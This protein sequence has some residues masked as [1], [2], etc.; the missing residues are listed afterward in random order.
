MKIKQYAAFAL[1]GL[2]LSACN[3]PGGEDPD[4][5][6][7]EGEMVNMRLAIK[8]PK[9]V[10]TYAPGD[11]DDHATPQEI[12]ANRVDVFI[13]DNGGGYALTHYPFTT[14]SATPATPG[15]GEFGFDNDDFL[16]GNFEVREG[17]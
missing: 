7:P 4:V 10:R 5:V 16:T 13:Y 3:K 9:S 12:R 11:D 17:E 8:M 14:L 1:M 15:E 2:A 6:E